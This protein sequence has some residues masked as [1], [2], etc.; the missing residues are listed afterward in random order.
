MTRRISV[1][2]V[3]VVISASMVGTRAAEPPV[4]DWPSYNRTLMSDRYVPFDQ[5]NKTNV[6]RLK[7]VCVYDLNVDASFQGGPIVIGRTMYLT[8]DKEIMAIDADTCQQKWRTREEG[9]SLA[10]RVNRGAAYLDGRLFRGTEKAMSS[11]TTRR[12]A[13]KCGA[14][15]SPSPHVPRACPQRLSRGTDWSSSAPRAAIGTA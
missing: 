12:P 8:T 3:S 6:S 4:T 14:R 9:P 11:R 13:R 5:I 2:F 7:Q 15:T 10:L 1:A